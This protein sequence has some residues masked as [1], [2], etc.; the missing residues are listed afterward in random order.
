LPERSAD[1]NN[2]QHRFTLIESGIFKK[3]YANDLTVVF[4]VGSEKTIPKSIETTI[5][6]LGAFNSGGAGVNNRT[7]RKKFRIADTLLFDAKKHSL[8]LGGEFEVERLNNVSENNLN[9]TFTFLI[10]TDFNNGRP[11]QYSQTLGKTEY[12]LTQSKAALFFQDDFRLN[13]TLQLGFGVRY[14]W[15]ND[16][17]DFDNFSPRM[18]YVWSPE[19]SGK[20]ILRGGIG[21][22]Y[23]WLDTGARAAILSNDGRQGQKLIIRSP[24]FPN[25]FNGGIVSQQL[26]QSISKL[27]DDLR[28]PKIFVT[29][30]SFNYK[31]GKSLTFEGIYTFKKGWNHFRSRNINAPIN[32]IRPDSNLG[33]IQLLESSGITREHSF[34][35]KVNSFY[36]G[37]NIFS[38]YEWSNDISDFSG[39]LSLPMDNYNLRL[40]RGPSSLEQAHKLNIVLNF[41][42]FKKINVS[43]SYRI[44]SGFPY[45]ITTGKDDNSDTVFNDRPLGFSR[46][47]ERGEF[48]SQ[49]DV[50]FRWKMPLQYLGL[51]PKNERPS[52]NL[53]ANI[54]NLFNT[55][56][57]TNYVGIQT[58][59][60][61]RQPTSARP[62]RTLEFGL[63]FSF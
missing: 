38:N 1:R 3:K 9:G 35:L 22:F 24:G 17:G 29:Q 61:F 39:P 23:D 44:E 51:K 43:P 11:S 52:L 7:D 5:L 27:A 19:K 18:G 60:F 45:T 26:P 48:L 14:E 8:K 54:R 21:V 20:F 25:P 34:E 6:V 37:I 4:T 46:N 50:R 57:L 40:E 15:Q 47:S 56:N 49:M 12:E 63:S 58:S 36:K 33:I 2:T 16:L 62:A 42:L 53:N 59:P 28:S 55:A 13:K 10:L 32:G 41:D 31:L 30:N